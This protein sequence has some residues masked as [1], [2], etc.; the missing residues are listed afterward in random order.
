MTLEQME[1][2]LCR[3]RTLLQAWSFR[4]APYVF[5][6]SE[7]SLFLSSLIP[8]EG[9]PWIYTRGIT[10]ALDYLQI[11]FQELLSLLLHVMP[12]LDGQTIVSKNT[13]D[14]TLARWMLP[15][16]PSEKQKLWQGSSMY[17]SP[18]KQTVGGAV[19]SFLLRPCAFLG[20]V[21]FGERKGTSPTFT[22]FRTWTGDEV[23]TDPDASKRLARKYLHCYG[24]ST[25]DG[26]AAWLGCSGKQAR[27]IWNT[28]KNEI[29]PATVLGK[30]AFFLSADREQIL[31]PPAPE[32]SLILLGGHDP[33]LDQRDR[34]I[35][36][37]DKALH[38]HIWKTVG[39]PGAVLCR[40]EIA[41]I[42]NSKKTKKGL[43][44]T[45]RIWN[46]AVDVKAVS[47]LAESYAAFRQ[48][49]LA[50]VEFL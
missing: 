13:L 47:G 12:A 3:E 38:R 44:L 41:G 1:I 16:I 48:E 37:P 27:R 9:E 26:L 50:R 24:P 35:L 40:G 4:G 14:E 8:E 22:S 45:L 15:Y 29:E 23:K 36:Q 7:S 31:S 28:V 11:K 25:S 2:F 34:L 32:R 49:N 6:T 39:N 20:L 5:P 17:G 10:L 33:Y 43:E 19:V 42:W 46:E 18:D 30:Q 21:V